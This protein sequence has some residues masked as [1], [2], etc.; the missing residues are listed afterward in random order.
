MAF[1]VIIL[2]LAGITTS[3]STTTTTNSTKLEL[4]HRERN[5][6]Y[7]HWFQQRMKRD[8]KRVVYL[9]NHIS[10]QKWKDTDGI[11]I[12]LGR[13]KQVSNK[14]TPGARGMSMVCAIKASRNAL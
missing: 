6:K 5:D 13:L 8:A 7:S 14:S 2:I 3:A 12:V 4:L 1:I 9:M 11:T 10:L